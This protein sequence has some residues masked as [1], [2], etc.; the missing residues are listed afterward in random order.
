MEL[1]ADEQHSETPYLSTSPSSL[2]PLPPNPSSLNSFKLVPPLN[3]FDTMNSFSKSS[4]SVV[5]SSQE[6]LISMTS[7][8]QSTYLNRK[9][10]GTVSR[11]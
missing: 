11:E 2:R 7:A 5:Y 10:N 8:L 3:S 4:L 1:R 9:E 6:D